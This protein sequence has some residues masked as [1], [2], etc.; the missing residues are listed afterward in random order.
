MEEGVLTMC[1][2]TFLYVRKVF[3][4]MGE[5][6]IVGRGAGIGSSEPRLVTEIITSNTS[7]AV[8][9]AINQSFSVRIFGAGG[10]GWY[11]SGGGNGICI[12]QYYI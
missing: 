2:Y 7:W 12:I 5:A 3:Y 8:P 4:F 6:I 1:Y 10:S 9:K 11:N